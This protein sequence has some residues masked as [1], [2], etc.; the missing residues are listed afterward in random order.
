MGWNY[1]EVWLEGVPG[2]HDIA[3]PP[4]LFLDAMPM[5]IQLRVYYQVP[6]LGCFKGE[7]GE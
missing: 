6:G 2:L 5:E 4:G 3:Q 1:F 7:I